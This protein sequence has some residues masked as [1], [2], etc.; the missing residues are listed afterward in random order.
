MSGPAP[1]IV[2]AVDFGTFGSGYAW[3]LMNP[4]GTY[5]PSHDINCNDQWAGAE[6]RYPK[7]RSAIL[8]DDRG[9][10]LA[11]GYEA[12]S[13]YT[14]SG[15]RAGGYAVDFKMRLASGGGP[16]SGSG[17]GVVRGHDKG[18]G[19]GGGSGGS[20]SSPSQAE[21][22]RNDTGRSTEYLIAA[23]LRELYAVAWQ[24]ILRA[25][26]GDLPT[27]WYLSVPAIWSDFDRQVMRRAAVEAGFP[28][29]PR[30]L[31]IVFEPEVAALYCMA[32]EART[33]GFGLPTDAPAPA[34][35]GAGGGSPRH[36]PG[37]QFVIVDC[38]GGTTDLVPLTM[39]PD[40][41]FDQTGVATGDTSG[42]NRVTRQFTL[43][44][45]AE[46]LGREALLRLVSEEP[47]AVG[48][49]VRAWEQAR[50]VFDPAQ[51]T[52][53]RIELPIRVWKKLPAAAVERLAAAQNGADDVVL[54][55][56]DRTRA[57][58]DASVDPICA[59]VDEQLLR[60][61]E[62]TRTLAP[63]EPAAQTAV[64]LV[65]GF[66]N[67]RYLQRR[68]EA[69]VE[70][71]ARLFVPPRPENAVLFGA[72]QYGNNPARIRS[73]TAGRTYGYGLLEAFDP[74][75]DPPERLYLNAEGKALCTGRFRVLV[76]RGE[77]IPA[78]KETTSRVFPRDG[79][80]TRMKLSFFASDAESPRY[81]DGGQVS[82]VGYVTIYLP[83][84]GNRRYTARERAIDVKT[85][86]GET[87][88]RVQAIDR[89]TGYQTDA[90]IE[91]T[92]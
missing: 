48:E 92:A 14:E 30:R 62:R 86:F 3:A 11:W 19:A 91:F 2:A 53:V 28:A 59:L 10:T 64:Y 22:G 26:Y 41:T 21:A 16:G 47:K 9:R 56:A 82:E 39:R 63:G 51:H 4:D 73:R 54:L 31:S 40:G 29:D 35:A 44:V 61:A 57:L 58:L 71:R 6:F 32:S 1:S 66:A 65:G 89:A 68:L 83:E 12:Q 55:S 37:S 72:V 80:Q 8:L 50:N 43:A 70:G 15:G 36:R 25:G 46:R 81:V 33:G 76:R 69:V 87:V 5:I 88:I 17:V 23:Y 84:V 38:G 45:L 49:L 24:H 13:R 52:P 90:E 34:P 79:N 60:I 78:G 74:A 77:V 20:G 67:S 18:P 7:N 85:I 27:S 75:L 42:A